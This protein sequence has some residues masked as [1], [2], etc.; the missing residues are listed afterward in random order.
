MYV[1]GS[2][3]SLQTEKADLYRL[4]GF[5]ST[6]L[7]SG[8]QIGSGN[9]VEGRVDNVKSLNLGRAVDKSRQRLQHLLVGMG[10][11]IVGIVL[12]I[13]QADCSHINSPGTSERDFVLK[14]ILFTK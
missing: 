11:V 8:Y 13:P 7:L 2:R 12:V 1:S 3:A 5:R 4:P 14:A 10:V 6:R 9:L